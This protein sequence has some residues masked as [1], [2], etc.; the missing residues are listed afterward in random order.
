MRIRIFKRSIVFITVLSLL[1]FIF[2]CS[3][4][5]E[6]EEVEVI[7]EEDTE[8]IVHIGIHTEIQEDPTSLDYSE[9]YWPSLVEL[10]ELA[11]DYGI[12][13]TIQFI[14]QTAEF[15]LQ[16]NKKLSIVRSWERYGHELGFHHHGLS[17]KYWDGYTNAYS[18]IPKKS[19]LKYLGKM[20]D[21][22]GLVNQ[23]SI[24]GQVLTV[25]IT[26]EGTDWIEGILYETEGFSDSD[27]SL[28]SE[29][30]TTEEG[31]IELYARPYAT[32]KKI[33]V[34]LREIEEALLNVP[35]GYYSGI[36]LSDNGY[37]T[38]KEEVEQL[39][40]FLQENNI[41]TQTIKETLSDYSS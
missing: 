14:P 26:D 12:K 40:Q 19:L 11:D 37:D 41:K 31:S 25:G 27:N 35:E 9:K 3:T 6:I 24:S 5:T 20:D 18:S 39:F 7:A 4:D 23:L 30:H 28:L 15:V 22:I 1:F 29:P 2:S 13:L 17:H 34:T 10:V 32:G 16:D 36:T 33:D 38:H 21:A 8:I